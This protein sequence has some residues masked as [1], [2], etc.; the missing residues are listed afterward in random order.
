MMLQDVIVSTI[1][2]YIHQY[3]E[4]SLPNYKIVTGK[5]LGPM[6]YSTNT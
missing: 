4:I 1:T 3:Q 5:A 6:F 2:K